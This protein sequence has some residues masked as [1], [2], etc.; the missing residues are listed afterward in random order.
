[1]HG[2]LSSNPS[3]RTALSVAIF[4]LLASGAA[5]AGGTAPTNTTTPISSQGY[6][7]LTPETTKDTQN[8]YSGVLGVAS[9]FTSINDSGTI[10]G[11]F[12]YKTGVSTIS[13][14]TQSHYYGFE[15]TS[16]VNITNNTNGPLFTPG[17]DNG[18]YGN[19]AVT[20]IA[21]NGYATYSGQA[22][23]ELSGAGGSF[24]SGQITLV[25]TNTLASGGIAS[26]YALGLDNTL[27]AGTNNISAG[28]VSYDGFLYNI[29]THAYTDYNY[30]GTISGS[31]VQTT[32]TGVQTDTGNSNVYVSG[33]F[34]DNA[35]THGLIYDVT[36]NTWTAVNDANATQGTFV[37]GLNASGE[38]VGYYVDGTG[39]HGFTYNY[40][41]NSFINADI[42]NPVSG[43]TNTVILGIN[44]SGTLVGAYTTS[45]NGAGS[46]IG[47]QATSISA[48]I[49][50]PEQLS[51]LLLGLLPMLGFSRRQQKPALSA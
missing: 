36:T 7:W 27:V 23:S 26:T 21:N 40:L 39:D 47:F 46:P 2:F 37:T 22:S 28:S 16:L 38:A 30:G 31:L 44:D 24:T 5:N 14:L 32:F 20:G 41:T 15:G 45:A 12:V 42:N 1:M 4:G 11:E 17:P 49:P 25:D 18:Y 33:N 50:E 3:V 43:T 13:G 19:N 10:S 35:G 48:P 51:L 9:T 8:G 6:D 29:S 34:D